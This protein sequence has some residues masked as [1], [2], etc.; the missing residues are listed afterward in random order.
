MCFS[1]TLFFFCCLCFSLISCKCTS[2]FRPLFLLHFFSKLS[3]YDLQ[4][5][6]SSGS[7]LLSILSMLFLLPRFCDL[8]CSVDSWSN[9]KCGFSSL[10]DFSKWV[11]D[12]FTILISFGDFSFLGIWSATRRDLSNFILF[13][14]KHQCVLRVLIFKRLLLNRLMFGLQF[15][16]LLDLLSSVSA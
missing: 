10:P 9:W 15:F 2:L 8:S 13:F 11:P 3:S 6:L 12:F 16:L 5:A 7:L 4:N 14:S 1:F